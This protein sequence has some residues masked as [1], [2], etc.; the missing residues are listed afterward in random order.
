MKWKNIFANISQPKIIL[1]TKKIAALERGAEQRSE[2]ERNE[3]RSVTSRSGNPERSDLGEDCEYYQSSLY[4]CIYTPSLPHL[5]TFL[6]DTP[7]PHILYLYS[8]IVTS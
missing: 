5:S 6:P 4:F 2:A 7:S 3:V 8:L 1:E